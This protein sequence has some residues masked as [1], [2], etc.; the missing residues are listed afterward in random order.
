MKVHDNLEPTMEFTTVSFEEFSPYSFT[1][2]LFYLGSD[3]FHKKEIFQF[4][5]GSNEV[6]PD[7][8]EAK[9]PH[10][11]VFTTNTQ[12]SFFYIMVGDK[13]RNIVCDLCELSSKKR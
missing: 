6:L 12:G 3:A 9:S 4:S 7:E 11:F 5:Y 2:F 8:G 13:H 10:H 1:Y